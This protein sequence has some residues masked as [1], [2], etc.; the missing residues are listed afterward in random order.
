MV[1]GFFEYLTHDGV[2]GSLKDVSDTHFQ[3][4]CF[5]KIVIT[6]NALSCLLYSF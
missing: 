2:H 6:A 5:E 3:C 4:F 1:Q